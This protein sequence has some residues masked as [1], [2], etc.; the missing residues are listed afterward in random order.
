MIERFE[1]MCKAADIRCRI[2]E[3]SGDPFAKLVEQSRYHDL[4]IFG[5]LSVFEYDFLDDDPEY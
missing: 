5:L 3:E 1:C 4:T 2:L